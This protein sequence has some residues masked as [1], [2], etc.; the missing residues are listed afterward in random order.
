M[1][2]INS[3]HFFAV[4]W[5]GSHVPTWIQSWLR[6]SLRVSVDFVV[7]VMLRGSQNHVPGGDRF[8]PLLSRLPWRAKNR[9]L[10]GE[11]TTGLCSTHKKWPTQLIIQLQKASTQLWLKQRADFFLDSTH[12]SS[13]LMKIWVDSNLTQRIHFKEWVDSTYICFESTQNWLKCRKKVVERGG[14]VKTPLVS[15]VSS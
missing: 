2:L 13:G 7:Y 6:N 14:G 4:M 5:L 8:W 11:C 15:L 1:I 12:D 9:K 10:K 3:P